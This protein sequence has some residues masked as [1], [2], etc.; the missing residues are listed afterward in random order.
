MKSFKISLAVL[1]IILAV[2]SAFTTKTAAQ[3]GWY[4]YPNSSQT[5]FSAT[6]EPSSANCETPLTPICYQRLDENGN[7]VSGTTVFGTYQ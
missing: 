4:I 7:V 2:G 5:F 3:A 1:A 6:E